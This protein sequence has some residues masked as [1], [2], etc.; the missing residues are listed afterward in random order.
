MNKKIRYKYVIGLRPIPM[1]MMNSKPNES[2]FNEDYKNSYGEWTNSNN[3]LWT[4]GA[5]II[6]NDKEVIS[7][8]FNDLANLVWLLRKINKELIIYLNEE[9]KKTIDNELENEFK[10]FF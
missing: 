1:L 8:R 10:H 7:Y 5:Y 6:Y 4:I 3:T 9:H 2:V